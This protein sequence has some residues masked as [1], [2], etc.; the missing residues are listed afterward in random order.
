MIDSLKVGVVNVLA[1]QTDTTTNWKRHVI[2]CGNCEDE[3]IRAEKAKNAK[4]K[5]GDNEK[6]EDENE[7]GA[8]EGDEHEGEEEEGGDEDDVVEP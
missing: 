2:A 5:T 7:C 1:N 3:L 8:T 4:K 6:K